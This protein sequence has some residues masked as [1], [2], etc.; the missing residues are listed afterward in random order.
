MD[1]RDGKPMRSLVAADHVLVRE[2]LGTVRAACPRW[3]ACAARPTS[4][5]LVLTMDDSKG[6]ARDPLKAG[7]RGGFPPNA[8]PS[9]PD[10]GRADA[11]SKTVCAPAV[12]GLR[13]RLNHEQLFIHH[14]LRKAA[15]EWVWFCG[16][17]GVLANPSRWRI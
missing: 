14:R 13:R 7:A 3:R 5:V 12:L 8:R 10:P 2:R 11:E 15:P 1:E 16:Q 4:A 17:A 9:P 6:F